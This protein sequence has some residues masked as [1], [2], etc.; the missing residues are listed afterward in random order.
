[1]VILILYSNALPASEFLSNDIGFSSGSG[2][3]NRSSGD[4]NKGTNKVASGQFDDVSAA[5]TTIAIPDKCDSS[6]RKPKDV[7]VSLTLVDGIENK[8]Q[9]NEPATSVLAGV[10]TSEN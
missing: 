10:P 1:M 5:S 6:L 7:E 3:G 9:G 8:G 2:V 4:G